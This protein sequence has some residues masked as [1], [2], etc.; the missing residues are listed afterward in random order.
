MRDIML[1]QSEEDIKNE[2]QE[3]KEIKENIPEGEVERLPPQA[4]SLMEMQD[5][6]DEFF[7]VPEPS[8]N[9]QLE[10]EWSSELSPEPHSPVLI[11]TVT[12]IDPPC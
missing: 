11:L 10:N 1:P 9:D 4:V 12:R 2:V 6:A 7:D 3:P 8:D 5:A